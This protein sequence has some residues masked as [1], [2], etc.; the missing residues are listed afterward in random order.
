[1]GGEVC[2]RMKRERGEIEYDCMIDEKM[3]QY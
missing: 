1:V 2:V 3:Y